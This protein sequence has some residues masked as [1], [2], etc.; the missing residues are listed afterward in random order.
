MRRSTSGRGVHPG[1]LHGDRPMESLAPSPNRPGQRKPG[2]PPRPH[3]A[4]GPGN[5][6]S[7]TRQVD[8]G[9]QSRL[10]LG[11]L[12][13]VPSSQPIIVRLLDKPTSR[14]PIARPPARDPCPI[15]LGRWR[16]SGAS[17]HDDWRRRL[18]ARHWTC[19]RR[20]GRASSSVARR[21][22]GKESARPKGRAIH[23]QTRRK[24]PPVVISTKMRANSSQMHTTARPTP[25]RASAREI[26]GRTRVAGARDVDS[27]SKQCTTIET[28]GLRANRQAAAEMVADAIRRVPGLVATS[29]LATGFRSGRASE[30]VPGRAQSNPR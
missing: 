24:A 6:S 25:E 20:F 8:V 14:R 12:L 9:D 27:S 23:K 18:A 2:Y 15:R 19:A 7:G 21:A 5:Q 26:G 11:G 22:H 30:P 16:R 10:P 29:R 4:A 1:R 3:A 17:D 28:T 13:A